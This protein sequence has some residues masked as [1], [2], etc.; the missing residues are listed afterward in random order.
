MSPTPTSTHGG[1]LAIDSSGNRLR[2]IKFAC[3]GDWFLDVHKNTSRILRMQGYIAKSGMLS[4]GIDGDYNVYIFYVKY[5]YE[6]CYMKKYNG[7]TWESEI[8]ITTGD[9][10]RP[11]CEQHSLLSAS[12]LNFVFY[13]D[14]I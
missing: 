4:L 10:L 13:T 8:A 3:G 12:K 1:A 2:F 11:S 9:G 6:K 7:S 14:I 5:S